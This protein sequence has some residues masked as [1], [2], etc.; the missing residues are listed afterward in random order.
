MIYTEYMAILKNIR[1]PILAIAVSVSV[2]GCQE[3]EN[4]GNEDGC[5]TISA[6][7]PDT[8]TYFGDKDSEGDGYPTLWEQGDRI[9]A[10]FDGTS[11]NLSEKTTVY[12]EGRSA[13]FSFRSSLLAGRENFTVYA[14]SPKDGYIQNVNDVHTGGAYNVISKGVRIWIPKVQTPGRSSVDCNAQILYAKSGPYATAD[15]DISLKFNHW[16][17]Y[18]RMTLKGLGLEEDDAVES[19]TITTEGER[20]L[21]CGYIHNIKKGTTEVGGTADLSLTINTDKTEDIWFGCFAGVDG[22]N[23]LSGSKFTV[24]VVTSKGA[25]HTREVDLTGRTLKFIAGRVSVFSVKMGDG[26]KPVTV[27]PEPD[28]TSFIRNPLNGWV[29]YLGRTWSDDFWTTYKPADGCTYD[30][31]PTSE[32]TTVRVSDY[33][34]TAYLRTKWATFNPEEGVYAWRDPNS[35]LAKELKTCLDRGMKLAFRFVFDGRDQGQN[36]PEYVINAGAECYSHGNYRSPYPDDPVFQEKFAKFIE[37]FA[38]D[39]NDPDKVD[40]I[41]AFSPGKWGEAHAVIY[42]DNANKMAFSEWMTSLYSRHF[43]KVP[44]F[45]NYHRMVADPNQES[46]SNTVPAE[47]EA[48]L[49]MAIDKGYSIRHDAF[50]M[51]DYYKQWEKDFAAK[52]NFKRPILMEGGWITGGTHRYWMDGTNWVESLAGINYREGHP[53]DV[54]LGEYNASREAHVNMM[55]FRTNNEIAT[56]FGL[57]FDLVKSFIAEGGYRLYPDAVT[58]PDEMVSGTVVKVTHSWTNL[59]WGYLP[60]NIPQWN[61]KYKVAV[62]LLDVNDDVRYCFVDGSAEPSEWIRGRSF[63]YDFSIDLGDVAAGSYTWAIGIVD[64]S[65]G[66]DVIGI[67]LALKK[68]NL[69]ENGWARLASVNVVR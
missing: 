52:W 8:K 21:S 37:E 45:I 53:E 43:T 12:D 20:Y 28:R 22:V 14:Y 13:A 57:S 51:S 31:M 40:F 25:V 64:T 26:N 16:T 59:G 9:S 10:S 62:A 56:W 66:N 39:F 36:T 3:A 15:E 54:R 61:H 60:N 69:T 2:T 63:P 23:D 46:F 67:N 38:K 50:G 7:S 41:D 32:G 55:D 24:K 48:I 58:V 33:A 29:M 44:I 27:R 65:K 17:A 49:E 4:P 30:A 42:R 47:T 68:D 35:N 34:N 1:I 19:V 6:S 11:Y 18:G 5:I